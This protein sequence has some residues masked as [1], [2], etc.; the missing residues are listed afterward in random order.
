M[1]SSGR[2]RRA[3]ACRGDPG[4]VV[5]GQQLSC[6]AR[7]VERR[8]DAQLLGQDAPVAVEH[9][10]RLGPATLLRQRVDQHPSRVF[11]Q[12][13]ASDEAPRG[14]RRPRPL[15][16]RASSDAEPLL[17]GPEAQLVEALDLDPT[18]VDVDRDRRTARRATAPAHRRGVR[19][20][21]RVLA[22]GAPSP[23]RAPVRTVRCRRGH[24]RRRG[25]RS[26]AGGAR[27]R[28][29]APA[30]GAGTPAT[31]APPR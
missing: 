13:F 23:A 19:A 26:P 31:A 7:S 22:R 27:P 25:A 8:G 2:R 15:G 12:R 6:R 20:P 21:A 29:P 16:R 11:A 3:A 18:V 5:L 10:Q 9:P 4:S 30:G 14:R 24:R 28:A 17:D 1:T